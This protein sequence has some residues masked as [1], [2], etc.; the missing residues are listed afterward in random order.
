MSKYGEELTLLCVVGGCC[1]K[2]A[3][4]VKWSPQ[5]STIFI[6]VKDLE[7]PQSSKYDGQVHRDGFTLVI[8]QFQKTDLDIPYACSYGY[9]VSTKKVLINE[10][11]FTGMSLVFLFSNNV[12][13]YSAPLTSE[14]WINHFIVQK[15]R[16]GMW[17]LDIKSLFLSWVSVILT[18]MVIFI[19]S[20]E[21]IH[22]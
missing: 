22:S 7:V 3:G 19:C 14:W 9:D 1:S 8:R 21:T 4:W 20:C 18:V 13:I 12:L 17:K 11:A 15:K 5:F 6:D 2:Q 16:N 10:S